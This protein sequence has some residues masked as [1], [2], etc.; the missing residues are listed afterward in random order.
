MR[1]TVLLLEGRMIG[2]A[3]SLKVTTLGQFSIFRNQDLLSGGSWNRRKVS[4]LFKV[5]LSAEQHRLHRETR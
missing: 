4:E 2:E 1:K 5:L 3:V